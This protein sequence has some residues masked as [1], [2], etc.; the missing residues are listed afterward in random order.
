MSY[1]DIKK[2]R[3]R[4]KEKIVMLMG[5]K[6]MCCGYSKCIKAMDLHHVDPTKKE[7]TIS[8]MIILNWKRIFKE[9]QKCV[10]VCSN[11]HREIHDNVTQCPEMV[12]IKYESLAPDRRIDWESLNLDKDAM[13]LNVK[14]LSK[15]Y[16]ISRTA[17]HKKC[18]ESNIKLKEIIRPSKFI[19]DYEKL[20][21][22]VTEMPFTKIGDMYGV[23]DNAI[24]KRCKVL[25]IKIPRF[26][27]GYWTK[28]KQ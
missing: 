27:R 3:R 18:K 9:C 4:F 25:G 7:F 12:D 24:R 8:Q 20:K 23:S 17:I 28:N 5:G 11:C 1:E 6:C 15:K 22:L 21:K 13:T 2:Y 10:L 14:E 19:V 26:G 16:G